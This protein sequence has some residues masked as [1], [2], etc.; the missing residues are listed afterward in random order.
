VKRKLFGKGIR[1]LEEGKYTINP[2][3]V[4]AYENGYFLC[5]WKGSKDKVKLPRIYICFDAENP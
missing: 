2:V 4:E 5:T 1:K 3:Q